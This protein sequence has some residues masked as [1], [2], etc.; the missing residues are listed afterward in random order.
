MGAGSLLQVTLL[1][2]GPA[3]PETSLRGTPDGAPA[4]DL[5]VLGAGWFAL[6]IAAWAEDCGW[7]VQGLVE[8]MDSA[9]VNTNHGGYDVVDAS[10]MPAGAF[11]IVAGGRSVDRR[12]AWELAAR[13][14]CTA[15]AIAHPRAHL[16]KSVTI[17]G[18]AIVGPMAVVGADAHVRE[19]ALVSRGCLV[20][21]HAVIG[22]FTRVYP[23]A[24]VAGH[25]R[26]GS[27][28]MLGMGATVADHVEIG[29]R[30]TV[31]AGA[32]VVRDVAAGARVQGVPARPY[33]S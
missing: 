17:E 22:D 27:D 10:A 30:A 15:V 16:A 9:R 28:T 14:G 5:F 6:E 31:A 29:E 18:G 13:Q 3:H 19:H 1:A 4:G 23:G 33:E 21:H 32:V 25:V 8:L 24:N 20:G 12:E 11:A 2:L 26:V 7:R